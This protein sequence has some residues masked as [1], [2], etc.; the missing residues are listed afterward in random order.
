M[1]RATTTPGLY[2]MPR[3]VTI[4]R[5]RHPGVDLKLR[6]ANSQVIEARAKERELDLGV[7]GGAPSEAGVV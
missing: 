5:A 7:V 2:V 3:L 6:I 4:F 1:A